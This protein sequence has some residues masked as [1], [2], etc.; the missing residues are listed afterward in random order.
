MWTLDRQSVRLQIAEFSAA[1][2]V[3]CPAAGL[4][5]LA[6]FQQPLAAC[7][8]LQI[9][10]PLNKEG[11]ESL[12][13]VYVRGTDLIASYALTEARNVEPHVRW[14]S[15]RFLERDVEAVGVELIV[16]MQT[17]LLDSDP[18]LSI[19]ST[20]IA[21]DVR[22]CLDPAKGEFQQLPVATEEKLR[23]HRAP[24]LCLLVFRLS[25]TN[26]SYIE[27]VPDT[28]YRGG[29]LHIS[30]QQPARIC[31]RC[32]IFD[33]RL[34]KGVIRRGRIWG[35]FVR[36]SHDLDMA[37]RCYRRLMSSPPPLTA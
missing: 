17:R 6:V 13:E 4:N 31:W 22:R 30:S 14:R 9:R 21:D 19:A 28:D 25:D 26:I 24:G 5:E 12:H 34:E 36:Q 33:E 15:L 8:V 10:E 32:N 1:I 23:V 27:I 16:S 37:L 18:K 35:L 2:D 11:H 3:L 29:E 20:L 7:R